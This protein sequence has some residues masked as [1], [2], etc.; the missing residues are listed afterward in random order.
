MPFDVLSARLSGRRFALVNADDLLVVS[1]PAI[2]SL[3]QPEAQMPFEVL[4]PTFTGP[5]LAALNIADILVGATPA[6]A[7]LL[8]PVAQMP[9][10]VLS[11]SVTGDRFAAVSM[12]ELL[13]GATPAMAPVCELV[14]HMFLKGL[15]VMVTGFPFAP[16]RMVDVC[17]P[18]WDVRWVSEWLLPVTEWLGSAAEGPL[19]VIVGARVLS[20]NMSDVIVGR[21]TYSAPTGVL[22]VLPWV[23]FCE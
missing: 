18:V 5:P 4:I 22:H 17:G 13:A 1:T 20:E 9:L 23:A 15:M 8:S 7:P 2:A 19:V 14:A 3:R 16:V 11:V 10:I 21:M 6:I 12:E